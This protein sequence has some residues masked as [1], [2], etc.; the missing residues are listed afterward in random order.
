MPIR[1]PLVFQVWILVFSFVT[2]YKEYYKKRSST[3]SNKGVNVSPKEKDTTTKIHQEPNT[4][5]FQSFAIQK[6]G[7]VENL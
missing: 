3:S 7:N 6:G 5:L 4:K 2:F 1:N